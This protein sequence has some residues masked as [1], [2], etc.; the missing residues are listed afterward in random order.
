MPINSTHPLY[1]AMLPKW[2]RCRDAYEGQDAI[3]ARGKTYLPKPGGMDADE[4]AEYLGRALYYEATGRTIDGFTGA[5]SRKDAKVEVPAQ[6]QPIVD[7][8]TADGV[9]LAELSKSM[10][11]ET[12]LEARGG[13]LVD[14]D[15]RLNRAYLSLWRTENITNWGDDE[16]ILFETVYERDAEDRFKHVAISQYR[17]LSLIDGIY[18]VTIWRKKK[19]ANG[20][21]DEW[22][23]YKDPLTPTKRGI[24][25][26]HIPFF[27]L[28]P[29]GN[30]ARIEN[31]PLL[32]LVDVCVAHFKNTADH[33][34]GLHFSGLPTLYATGVTDPEKPVKIGSM[35]VMHLPQAD[36][37]L[38]YAEFNGDGLGA[39]ERAIADK[40]QKM[41]VLGAAVFHDDKKGVEAADTTRIRTSSETSLLIGVTTAVEATIKQALECAAKW[42]GV[43]GKIE[44]TLNRQFIDTKIDGPTLVG[45][46]TA[47]Q[48]GGMSLP[49]FLYNLEQGE[50]LAPDTDLKEEAA[51]VEAAVKQAAEFTAALEAKSKG[52]V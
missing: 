22:E 15:A 13:I 6:L 7:D 16:I 51:I 29:L 20:T 46:V 17:Q 31:P 47:Y 21:A 24:A 10:C 39:L 50:M 5:I 35:T 48:S 2:Q 32:G 40:E 34:H 41:G 27:W 26:D 28:T 18:T 12:I 43:A 8:A 30:T 9:S 19:N 3:K 42:M 52:P 33:E 49:Q 37:K 11:C 14:Y 36:C 44:V 25:L 23:I 4:Y 45:L 1:D 38:A